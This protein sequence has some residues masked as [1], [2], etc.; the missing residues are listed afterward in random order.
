MTQD[1]GGPPDGVIVSNRFIRGRRVLLS[2]IDAGGLFVDYYLHRKD[3]LLEYPPALDAH[4][5]DLLAAFTLHGAAQPRN[6]VL[7]WTVRFPDPLCSI[8]LGGDT[9]WGTVAGRVFTE[10][11]REGGM[12]ELYQDLKVPGRPLHRSM[13]DFDGVGAAAAIERFYAQSEQRP[14]R[15]FPLEGDRYALLTA[16]PDYDEEWF[17]SLDHSVVRRLSEDED[18]RPIETRVFRWFCGCSHEKILQVLVPVMRE[19][20]DQLFEGEESIEVNCPRCGA[21]Y[22]VTQEALE[23]QL[24]RS[25][26]DQGPG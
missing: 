18:L 21:R 16:H 6:R 22:R 25:E 17:A 19:N 26:S 12:A 9:E 23:D 4:F 2:E 1:N 3:H 13:V 8:F 15:F 20:P 7:A 10:N 5:K 24:V 11:V 14:C